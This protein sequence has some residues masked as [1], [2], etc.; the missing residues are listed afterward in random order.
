MTTPLPSSKS[1]ADCVIDHTLDAKTADELA[2]RLERGLSHA[3]AV[4]LLRDEHGID[5][6]QSAVSRWA[7]RRRR[8]KN[9]LTFAALREQMKASGRQA[10]S[11]RGEARSLKALHEANLLLVT[12]SLFVAQR[13]GDEAGVAHA[14]RV[15]STVMGAVTKARRAETSELASAQRGLERAQAEL[16]RAAAALQK[17][18]L[19]EEVAEVAQLKVE[20]DPVQAARDHTEALWEISQAKDLSAHEK[21]ARAAAVI[22][23][24]AQA[25]VAPAA[26]TTPETANPEDG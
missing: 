14:A 2:D 8:A 22:F 25:P 18:R 4:R 21:G 19:A 9:D 16:S 13:T 20:F 10:V 6:S 5:L 1:R 26:E 24:R 12:Q 23:G 17:S 15:F 11:L 3:E 7:S